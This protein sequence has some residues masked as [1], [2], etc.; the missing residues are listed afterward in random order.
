MFHSC[1]SPCTLF[2][3]ETILLSQKLLQQQ[4][5][6]IKSVWY[7]FAAT[8]NFSIVQVCTRSHMQYNY[9][10]QLFFNQFKYRFHVLIWALFPIH[11]KTNKMADEDVTKRKLSNNNPFGSGD[12]SLEIMK[13]K[14]LLKKTWSTLYIKSIQST[15]L[16]RF[17]VL[18]KQHWLSSIRKTLEKKTWT[19]KVEMLWGSPVF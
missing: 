11:I 6:Y 13:K 8:T 7:F 9:L 1:V 14:S 19:R 17:F 4:K 3:C 2:C 10:W 18:F 5:K 12:Y 15:L 16:G